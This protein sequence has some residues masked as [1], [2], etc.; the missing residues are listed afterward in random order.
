MRKPK[1]SLSVLSLIIALGIPSLSSAK[2]KLAVMDLKPGHGV[3]ESLADALSVEV[4]DAIHSFGDYEV[5]SKEDLAAIAE[6]TRMRQSLGCDD[7]QCLIDFGQAIGTRYMVAG[8]IS[9][10]G[11]TYSINLRLIDTEGEDPGVK[12]RASEKC[13]CPEDELYQTA[14]AAA[15]LVMGK[16][17]PEAKKTAA[18]QPKKVSSAPEREQVK[19]V[20]QDSFLEI[21]VESVFR[22]QEYLVAKLT[23]RNKSEV[24]FRLDVNE[25][26]AY[27][28]D[29]VGNKWT[30][31]PSKDA[32]GLHLGKFMPA[33]S[34]LK[35]E[36]WFQN[37]SGAVPQG[38]V[39]LFIQHHEGWE[40]H[41]FVA[42]VRGIPL[43]E[44]SRTPEAVSAEAMEQGLFG[45]NPQ[46]P[47]KEQA[48]CFIG[49]VSSQ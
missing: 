8:F 42:I 32:A 36:V 7:T 20:W 6:R 4:R 11:N 34:V 37:R 41:R 14:K 23:F 29:A 22:W 13:A 30:F 12:N 10:L 31:V 5:L 19:Y 1:F 39:D 48:P 40:G 18:T 3:E 9:K 28:S 24:Q 33:G 35:G 2:E 44:G 46:P 25:Y 27:I 26:D 15:A 43:E 49:A 47:P 16:E 21:Q 45:T 38:N 17:M